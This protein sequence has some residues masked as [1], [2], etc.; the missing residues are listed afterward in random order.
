M[1][2]LDRETGEMTFADGLRLCAGFAMGEIAQLLEGRSSGLVRLSS[3]PVAGG[4]LAPLCE[5]LDGSVQSVSLCVSSIGGKTGVTASRQRAFLFARLGLQD[6]DEQG[7]GSVRIS[8]PFGVID[9]TTDPY[10]GRTE[11]RVT[12]AVR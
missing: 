9:I 1:A 8:C 7:M 10:T 11:A 6:P 3:H 2:F 4:R 12:Y 5:V